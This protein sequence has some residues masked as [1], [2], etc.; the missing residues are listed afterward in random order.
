[1]DL[2][3]SKFG[4]SASNPFTQPSL[5]RWALYERKIFSYAQTD[6][7]HGEVNGDLTI[8]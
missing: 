5:L 6:P 3:S 1:M 4:I 2:A 8:A 7:D